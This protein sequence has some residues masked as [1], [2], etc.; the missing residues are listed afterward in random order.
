MSMATAV[1]DADAVP[2]PPVLISMP[3]IMKYVSPAVK[4]THLHHDEM[5][6]DHLAFDDTE[7][8]GIDPSSAAHSLYHSID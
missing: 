1:V 2:S 4:I 8:A 5:V 6:N 3:A 7:S